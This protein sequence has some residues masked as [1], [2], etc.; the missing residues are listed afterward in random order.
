LENVEFTQLLKNNNPLNLKFSSA[1]RLNATFPYVLPMV[2]MP[3][4]PSIEVM[5]AGLRDNYGL[6][7]S[8]EFIRSFKNWIA[9]NTSGIILVEIRD[10][11]KFFDVD[12]RENGSIMRR[13]SAPFSSV[14]GNILRTHDYNNDQLLQNAMEWF[15][16]EL[17]VISFYL[18]QDKK[19]KISMSFHLTKRDKQR[20]INSLDSDDNQKSL[21]K[22]TEL[23]NQ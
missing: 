9:T 2:S 13:L 17:D 7:T 20:I 19:D 14:Y 4:E 15:P 3:T 21:K 11:Q 16:G 10:E 5:D 1:I 6:K 23:I 12:D 8:L 18:E 22:L